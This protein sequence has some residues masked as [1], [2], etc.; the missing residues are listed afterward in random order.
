VAVSDGE[1]AMKKTKQDDR[2]NERAQNIEVGYAIR[3]IN[4][5]YYECNSIGDTALAGTPL[6]CEV[7]ETLEGAQE[8]IESDESLD[9]DEC[10]I[11]AIQRVSAALVTRPSAGRGVGDE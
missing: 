10:A 3:D 11:V 8:A 6:T 9:A 1:W 2:D 4:G 5:G 7:F